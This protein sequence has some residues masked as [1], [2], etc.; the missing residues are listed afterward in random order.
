MGY[1][2]E[3]WAKVR[4]DWESGEY[5]LE[6]LSEIYQVSRQAI[7]VHKKREGWVKGVPAPTQSQEYLESVAEEMEAALEA[8]ISDDL[9]PPVEETIGQT[10]EAEPSQTETLN[11]VIDEEPVDVSS[12]EQRI[13]ELEAKL[14]AAEAEVA[15]HDPRVEVPHLA[16]PDD[17]L[18]HV[19]YDDLAAVE[20]IRGHRLFCSNRHRKAGCGRTTLV[21]A[22]TSLPRR[23]SASGRS[24]WR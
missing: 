4:A 15:I 16:S 7:S 8:P 20:R 12:Y 14:A 19:G 5:G 22:A 18:E 6:K 1:T 2:P 9:P 24:G 17:Y 3:F 23:R 13:A 21:Y 11:P 10:I